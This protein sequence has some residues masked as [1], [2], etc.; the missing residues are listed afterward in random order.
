MELRQLEVFLAVVETGTIS[1][2]ARRLGSAQSAVSTVVRALEEDL[3]AP[4]FT[5]TS[6]RAVPTDAGLALLPQARRLL[7]GA[8]DARA[9]VRDAGDGPS[10][11]LAVG[12]VT[13]MHPVDLPRL[14]H[15]YTTAHPRVSVSMRVVADGSRGLLRALVEGE[16]DVAFLSWPFRPPAALDVRPLVR[17][18]FRLLLPPE[19][20]LAGDRPVE[21]T[22]LAGE[23]WID[24]PPGFGNRLQVDALFERAGA[25]RSVRLEV[26]DVST[27][28][29]YVAA[30]LGV[31]F[32]PGTVPVPR[33]VREQAVAGDTLVWELSLASARPT[34]ERPARR[35]VTA[36]CREVERDA[37]VSTRGR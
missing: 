19:H 37:R 4:L 35:A 24:G 14:L 6:R 28:P 17:T 2:A 10:G 13:T 30:G 32:V 16:L 25:R 21:L 11:P 9:V 34:A 8:A 33:G 7:A 27:F 36:F 29:R 5:R 23:R 15:R 22:D 26:P 31:A 20:P 12:V 18:S 1:A 3:G